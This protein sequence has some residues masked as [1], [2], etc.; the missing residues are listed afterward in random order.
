MQAASS[1]R[2][3]SSIRG[4][5]LHA[6]L[7]APSPRRPA[8]R[9]RRSLAMAAAASP[10]YVVLVTGELANGRL[11]MATGRSGAGPGSECGAR[12]VSTRARLPVLMLHEGALHR[13]RAA[14][15]HG[16][17]DE[18]PE[19]TFS[20]CGIENGVDKHLG[21]TSCCTSGSPGAPQR[22]QAR[23]SQGA[24]RSSSPT[25]SRWCA[26]GGDLVGT[27]RRVPPGNHAPCLRCE[28]GP[29]RPAT[30]LRRRPTTWRRTRT[31]P[32][33]TS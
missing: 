2:A 27:Q 31:G 3:L 25:S 15:I 8:A 22:T 29:R 7:A 18:A 24:S 21:S 19:Q 5:L 12:G 13:G 11:R 17:G 30:P 10:V 32:C 1:T 23:S 26:P 20:A 6:R 16:D 33:R 28:G 4:G 9:T 14:R